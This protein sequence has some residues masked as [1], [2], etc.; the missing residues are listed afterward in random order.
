MCYVILSRIVC[1]EQLHLLTFD[2]SKIYCNEEAKEEARSIKARAL[3]KQF[4]NWN[5][6]Q[7]NCFKISSLNVRSLQ[8]HFQD[9]KD[10]NFLQQS[11]ILC[12]NETWLVD[13]PDTNFSGFNSHYLNKRSKGIAMFTRIDPEEM[14][15]VHTETMSMLFARFKMFDLLSIYKFA[16]ASCIDEF[17]EQVLEYVDLTR[18]VILIGDINIDLLKQPHNKFSKQLK[19]LGFIQLV[20]EA[21]HISGGLL[22][23]LYVY[24][25]KDGHCE[26]FKIHPL[27]YSDHD[28]VCCILEFP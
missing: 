14:K 4:T 18:P 19:C 27:Y 25:P 1:L 5:L 17:I 6:R 10:D 22:D 8:K 26:L 13:D 2:P 15:K 16:D 21:T 9:L 24:F 7:R 12:V 3:N 23:H 20:K 28:A 11:D